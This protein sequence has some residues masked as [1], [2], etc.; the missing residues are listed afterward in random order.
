MEVDQL[1]QDLGFLLSRR[2]GLYSCERNAAVRAD[3][4]EPPAVWRD[5]YEASTAFGDR[6][7]DV[8]LLYA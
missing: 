4:A 3:D 8:E 6:G 7:R 2:R 1:G 5:C